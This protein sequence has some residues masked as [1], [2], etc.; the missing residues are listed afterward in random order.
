MMAKRLISYRNEV[1]KP[2]FNMIERNLWC[3]YDVTC[4]HILDMY[5]GILLQCPLL[6]HKQHKKRPHTSTT[7]TKMC[8]RISFQIFKGLSS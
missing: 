5:T 8:K 3:L 2:W 4:Y 1:L 6:G 7:Y